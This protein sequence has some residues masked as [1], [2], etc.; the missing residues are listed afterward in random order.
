MP[1]DAR[2]DA[3]LAKAPEF[4]KP[5]L[6]HLRALAHEACPGVEEALK[7]RMPHFLH[8]GILFG[9]AAFKQHCS[10]HFWKGKLLLEGNPLPGGFGNLGKVTHLS[11]LPDKKHLLRYIQRAM[12]LN[13]NDC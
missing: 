9:M 7:W 4:A 12:E 13:E 2:V 3:Y 1:K 6:T 5:I 11:E 8:K 10:V